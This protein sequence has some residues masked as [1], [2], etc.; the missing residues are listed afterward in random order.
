VADPIRG[1]ELARRPAVMNMVTFP[2]VL[3]YFNAS[4]QI[5]GDRRRPARRSTTLA[6]VL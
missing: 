1:G 5:W 6:G 3:W 4:A 2:V